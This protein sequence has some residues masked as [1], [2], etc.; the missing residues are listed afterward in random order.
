MQ[1]GVLYFVSGVGVMLRSTCPER[2]LI[3]ILQLALPQA[4]SVSVD[5]YSVLRLLNGWWNSSM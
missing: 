5:V 2:D 3:V 1:G 4:L